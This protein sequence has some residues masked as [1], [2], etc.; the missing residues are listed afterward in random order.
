MAESS[1]EYRLGL[2]L[3]AVFWRLLAVLSEHSMMIRRTLLTLRVCLLF[4]KP[5]RIEFVEFNSYLKAYFFWRMMWE[6]EVL[7]RL[8]GEDSATLS[9][10]WQIRWRAIMVVVRL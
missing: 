10:C 8:V 5:W 9:R 2:V 3:S 6:L 1:F 7:R 4:G